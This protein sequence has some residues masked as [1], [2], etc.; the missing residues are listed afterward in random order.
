[1]WYVVTM[2]P[3]VVWCLLWVLAHWGPYCELFPFVKSMWLARTLRLREVIFQSVC[4]VRS[5]LVL[6]V[7]LQAPLCTLRFI[8]PRCCSDSVVRICALQTT[9]C[10]RSWARTPTPPR[11]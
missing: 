1:M 11:K 4:E 10:C 5:V 7:C 9:R 3:M 8:S 6:R 2:L